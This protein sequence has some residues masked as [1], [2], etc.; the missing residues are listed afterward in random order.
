MNDMINST[1]KENLQ[2]PPPP[3]PTHWIETECRLWGG[4]HVVGGN[5]IQIS[6]CGREGSSF[7]TKLSLFGLC[8][9]ISLVFVVEYFTY[10]WLP[11]ANTF[12]FPYATLWLCKLTSCHLECCGH[13]LSSRETLERFEQAH[14][15]SEPMFEWPVMFSYI[16][17]LSPP[18]FI[19]HLSMH[20]KIGLRNERRLCDGEHPDWYHSFTV[21]SY[22]WW[23]LSMCRLTIPALLVWMCLT[24]WP[25]AACV[26]VS[27]IADPHTSS[28]QV[29]A[30]MSSH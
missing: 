30:I 16:S 20:I 29:V 13:D 22:C 9:A 1:I 21:S 24:T 3:P 28:V 23:T 18:C 19:D 4:L 27:M 2:S 6:W 8:L 5:E 7:S 15:W 26:I 25:S 11:R 10:T 12:L 14:H 17:L